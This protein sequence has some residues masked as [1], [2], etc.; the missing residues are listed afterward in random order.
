MF[1]KI[2]T[3]IPNCITLLRMMGTVW[4][5]H[6]PPLSAVFF[7][8]YTLTGFTDA[9]DGW[10]ARKLGTA[11][12]LGARL[13]SVADLLFYAVMLI[14]LCPVLR[15]IVPIEL[16]YAVGGVLLLRLLSYAVVWVKYRLFASVH[17]YLNKLTGTAVFMVPY[18]ISLP[19]AI[20][21]CWLICGIAALSSIEELLI[22]LCRKSYQTNT[23]S[24][25]KGGMP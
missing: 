15:S 25:W 9:L 24:F 18:V 6:V 10:A 13:D 12:E 2:K 11:S 23:K 3:N 16:W 22:H 14:R 20:S 1:Q 8:V 7:V 5:L 4:L 21:L 19:S 17:T